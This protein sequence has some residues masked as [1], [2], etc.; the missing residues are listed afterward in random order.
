MTAQ[1][2]T[3]LLCLCVADPAAIPSS[4]GAPGTLVSSESVLFIQLWKKGNISEI[5][6]LPH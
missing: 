2:Y 6:S 1:F 5:A 3:V 4:N